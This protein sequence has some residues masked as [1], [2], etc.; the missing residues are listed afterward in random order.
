MTDRQATE[1]NKGFLGWLRIATIG[2]NP[3]TTLV[4]AAVLGVLCW[5]IFDYAILPIRVTGISM[6]PTYH[7]NSANFINRL[8]YKRHE[9]QRG[10][11]VGI[12]LTPDDGSKPSIVYLKRVIALPGETVA[13]RGGHVKINGELLDE[14]YEKTK[15]DWNTVSMTLGSNDYFV[16]GDNRTMSQFDHF[17]GKVERTRIVGKVVR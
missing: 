7:D 10:D 17:F 3:A 8:A 15:C 11:V 14:P 4:R 12:R 9:P 1:S 13:F 2:R 6:E 16:V 5:L